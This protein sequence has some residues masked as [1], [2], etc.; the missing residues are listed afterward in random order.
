MRPAGGPRGYPG[1][2]RLPVER[3]AR[4]TGGGFACNLWWGQDREKGA[5]R[6]RNHG[7]VEKKAGEYSLVG[8]DDLDAEHA[9]C[10]RIA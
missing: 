2:S 8:Y 10:L 9:R 7:S 3:T 6:L 1:S 4:V 5:Y